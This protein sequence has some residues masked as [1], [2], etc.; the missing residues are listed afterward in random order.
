MASKCQCCRHLETLEHVMLHNV[1]VHK[2]W[3]W[4]SDLLLVPCSPQHSVSARLNAWRESSDHVKKDHI[5]ICIPMLLAWY[6][7]QARNAAKFRNKKITGYG[8]GAATMRQLSLIHHAFSVP[9]SFWKGDA[10]LAELWGF[11]LKRNI[12]KPLILVYWK[13]PPVH[14]V[15]LNT[16][17]SVLTSSNIASAAGIVRCSNGRVLKIFHRVI[18]RRTS[19]EAELEAISLV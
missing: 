5:R 19:F 17:A 6:A 12:P 2:A 9:I 1:E 7:W 15:K 11:Q 14:W 16:D 3:K 13:R 8:I 4:F 10:S 18:G